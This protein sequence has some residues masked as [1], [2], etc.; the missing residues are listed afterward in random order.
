MA[1][2]AMKSAGVVTPPLPPVPGVEVDDV[3]GFKKKRTKRPRGDETPA[4]PTEEERYLALCLIM[5]ARGEDPSRQ[6]DAPPEAKEKQDF[7]PGMNDDVSL[8]FWPPITNLCFACCLLWRL[9]VIEPGDLVAVTFSSWL[10]NLKKAY[11]VINWNR[12]DPLEN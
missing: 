6:R 1:L 11:L 8:L 9:F 10:V 3:N 5:L 7:M 12:V 4:P 2:E